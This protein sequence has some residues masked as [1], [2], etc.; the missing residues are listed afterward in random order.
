MNKYNIRYWSGKNPH[1]AQHPEKLIWT[2]ILGHSI[3]LFVERSLT[4][5]SLFLWREQIYLRMTEISKNDD[6]LV[7]VH[8]T[9]FHPMLSQRTSSFGKVLYQK[10]IQLNPKN[11][12]I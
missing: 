5:E 7:K 12:V 10:F 9:S 4:E 6:E 8:S 1:Y 3:G 11:V 2:G